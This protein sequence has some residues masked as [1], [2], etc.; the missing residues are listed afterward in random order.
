MSSSILTDAVQMVLFGVLLFIILGYIL[1]TSEFSFQEYLHTGEWKMS[2]GV[3]FS[4]W[5]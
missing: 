2:T 4:G 5:Q 1:P 3:D